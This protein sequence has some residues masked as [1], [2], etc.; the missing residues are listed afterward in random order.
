M[1][2]SNIYF[3]FI[4]LV[5]FG[6]A[7][8]AYSGSVKPSIGTP[9]ANVKYNDD[10]Y[11][12]V[13]AYLCR[14]PNGGGGGIFVIDCVDDVNQPDKHLFFCVMLKTKSDLSSPVSFESYAT[15]GNVRFTLN[16]Q[17]ADNDDAKV[18]SENG[19]TTVIAKNEINIKTDLNSTGYNGSI[20]GLNIAACSSIQ[21]DNAKII[22]QS[23][24]W[25]MNCAVMYED[26]TEQTIVPDKLDKNDAINLLLT[27]LLI[28][29]GVYTMGPSI[30]K[31]L[32]YKMTDVS[33]ESLNGHWGITL[34]SAAVLCIVTGVMFKTKA[35]YFIAITLLI[36]YFAGSQ[37]VRAFLE[38]NDPETLNDEG[39]PFGVIS[40]FLLSPPRGVA[41]VLSFIYF[42]LMALLGNLVGMKDKGHGHHYFNAML[43]SFLLTSTA[44]TLPV[45]FGSGYGAIILIIIGVLMSILYPSLISAKE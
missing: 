22:K 21:N 30:Y 16:D 45:N 42:L 15:G 1:S 44:E 26:E 43:I 4:E 38:K 6:V 9:S 24:E 19:K 10:N 17:L 7:E 8:K 35:H 25:E 37:S 23:L 11:F 27:T 40:T 14:D 18:Y 31:A 12:A 34:I 29:G 20:S 41:I 13:K 28:A 2:M 33:F 36:S 5:S 3:N 39:N 32:Y